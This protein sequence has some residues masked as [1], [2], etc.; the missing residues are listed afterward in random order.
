MARP[1][2]FKLGVWR[3]TIRISHRRHNL[4]GQR[5]RS[6]CHVICLSRVSPMARKS[7]TNSRSI[8]KI[9]TWYSDKVPKRVWPTIAVTSKVKGQGHKLTS[10]VRLISASSWFG[11]QNVVGLPVSLEAGG[12]IPCWPIPAATLLVRSFI[13]KFIRA[14]WFITQCYTWK[15]VEQYSAWPLSL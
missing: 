5:S 2:N 8:T 13:R 4:Q 15:H 14:L 3:T 6:Q 10:S 7:K 11:K 1:T 12:G 9:C